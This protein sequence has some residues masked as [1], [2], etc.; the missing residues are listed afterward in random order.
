[1]YIKTER[2][3]NPIRKILGEKCKPLHLRGKGS[4]ICWWGCCL[5]SFFT[6]ET[7]GIYLD[8]GFWDPKIDGTSGGER[9]RERDLLTCVVG[10]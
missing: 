5:I 3:E 7:A 6:L 10:C 1:M 2:F 8:L 4:G 9:E